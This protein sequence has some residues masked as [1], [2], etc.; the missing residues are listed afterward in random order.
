MFCSVRLPPGEY[1]FLVLDDAV[2]AGSTVSVLVDGTFLDV[3]NTVARFVTPEEALQEKGIFVAPLTM[4]YSPQEGYSVWARGLVTFTPESYP[5]VTKL[6][7]LS[8]VS[9]PQ[10]TQYLQLTLLQIVQDTQE[11]PGRSA[12]WKVS[13][14]ISAPLQRRMTLPLPEKDTLS[15]E[16]T[17]AFVV[18]VEAKLP[19]GVRRPAGN[20]SLQLFVP[21]INARPGCQEPPPFELLPLSVEKVTRWR[22]TGA[23]NS[24]GLVLCERI[25][26]PA[27][28]EDVFC[29][30]RASLSSSKKAL[31]HATLVAQLPPLEEWRMKK[32]DGSD[33]EPLVPGAV[34]DPRDYKSRHNW[35][36]RCH[37][38][39]ASTGEEVA[40]IQHALLCQGSTY[41]LYVHL[42]SSFEPSLLEGAQWL[43]EVFGSGA[44]EVGADTM[45]QDLQ[46][47]VRKTWEEEALHLD[48]AAAEDPDR[49]PRSQV[50]AACRQKW[51]HQKG[52]IKAPEGSEQTEE[53]QKVEPQQ[54]TVPGLAGALE[55]VRAQQHHSGYVE[56]FLQSHAE[57][58][59]V[60]VMEDPHL[61]LTD[62]SKQPPPGVFSLV[63]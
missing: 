35:L 27:G 18:L 58:E 11:I 54:V 3:P 29:T 23:P 16:A 36:S 24:K 6:E 7:L 59:A 31:I 19:P 37:R 47:Q 10:I 17:I 12:G 57:E 53:P 14:V 28:A 5:D 45:E 41:L 43:L 4:P 25:T 48:P 42:D 13:S 63:A 26:V 62:P 34:L 15:P 32:E 21:D 22:S 52:L 9:D 61:I 51:L 38:M 44:V 56:K 49:P 50:A 20:L 1:W 39:A 60:L 30:I 46:A 33:P 2:A 55:R 8:Y 40:V